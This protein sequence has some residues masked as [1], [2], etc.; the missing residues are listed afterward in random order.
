MKS[1]LTGTR[2][3]LLRTRL[4]SE[5]LRNVFTLATGTAIA[6]FIPILAA[7]ILSRLFSPAD[8]GLMAL[9]SSVAGLLAIGATGM[10]AP[11][12]ILAKDN[13]EAANLLALA[14]NISLIFG[15][16]TILVVVVFHQ[17]L[18]T[19]LHNP[20]ISPWLYV[21]PISVFLSGLLQG[22][23]NWSNRKQQYKRLA[24]NRVAGSVIGTGV[25]VTAGMAQAGG[26]GLIVGLL[27]GIGVS[28]ALLGGQT[29]REDRTNLKEATPVGMRLV[30]RAYRRFPIYVLP[31]EFIN[32]ATNQVPVFVLNSLANA[33]SVGLYGMTQ[34]VLGLP[35]TL[36]AS[37]ITDVFKQRAAS[38]YLK[39]GNCRDIY[40]KTFKLL[41]ALAI[42]PFGLLFLFGP[43]LF[44]FV[45]GER[46]A[47][48]GEYARFMSI[49][50]GIGFVAS[51]LSY[52]YFIAGKQREDLLLHVYMAFSTGFA[53]ALGY[54]L[55][56]E[57]R[58]MILCFSLN[59]SLI[60]IFYL[61]RSYFFAKGIQPRHKESRA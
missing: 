50:F 28:A 8:Y 58:Y 49:M 18:L 11:A 19:A 32:V 61:I 1:V 2:I 24:T 5:F 43:E 46:W 17:A 51:P 55:T 56:Y 29:W 33:A 6:Q 41:T 36:I 34:R 10:Y 59:Y 3:T 25:Q 26:G 52:V 14:V 39:Y 54:T 42:V 30:A 45:F 47:P 38:D 9:Y 15:L 44:G 57:P 60:Y 48:A 4:R 23:T 13:R 20:E 31:T 22:L 27:S 53:L 35:S 21:M 40:V 16:F 7:P 12:I 37:S